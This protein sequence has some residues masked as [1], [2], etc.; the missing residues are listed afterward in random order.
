[1]AMNGGTVEVGE[2]MLGGKSRSTVS[3]PLQKRIV[4]GSV[5]GNA[6][7]CN[8][9]KREGEILYRTR[10]CGHDSIILLRVNN[11]AII[12]SARN[13]RITCEFVWS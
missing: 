12:N 3:N 2:L 9:E 11:R 1:M 5:R 7:M 8:A 4:S 13:I 6:R 10:L